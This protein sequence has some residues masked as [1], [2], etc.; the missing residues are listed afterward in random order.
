MIAKRK[1]RVARRGLKEARSKPASRW[2]RTRFEAYGA[3]RASKG[4]QSPHPS[5][6]LAVLMGLHS[7]AAALRRMLAPRRRAT[8][9]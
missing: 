4:S 9:A 6:A 5:K 8:T 3:G 2:T 1:G 7:Q